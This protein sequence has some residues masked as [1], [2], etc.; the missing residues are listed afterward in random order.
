M[1]INLPPGFTN[2]ATLGTTFSR[3]MKETSTT[4]MPATAAFR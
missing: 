1:Q 4:A 3:E 2:L